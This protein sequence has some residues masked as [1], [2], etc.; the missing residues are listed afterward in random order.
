MHDVNTDSL[1]LAPVNVNDVV[2]PGTTTA[3]QPPVDPACRLLN[4]LLVNVNGELLD[5]ALVPTMLTAPPDVPL[6]PSLNVLLVNDVLMPSK[7]PIVSTPIDPP[8]AIA[9]VASQPLK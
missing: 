8:T 6:Y 5:V 3:T 4:V 7:S 9:L 2:D 1:P